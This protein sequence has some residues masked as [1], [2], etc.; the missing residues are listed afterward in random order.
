M[1]EARAVQAIK[2]LNVYQRINEVRKKVWY[3]RK[4]KDVS[5]GGSGNYKATTH[6]AVTALVRNHLIEHGVLIV[7]RLINSSMT[8][9]GKT[10]GGTPIF[11]YAGRFEVDFVNCDEPD[12]RIVYP[13]E[14]HANDSG[15]KAPGKAVSYATKYAILKLFNIETGENEEG[16]VEPYGGIEKVSEEQ[17]AELEALITEVGANRNAFLKVCKVEKLEDLPASK[18]EGAVQKLEAK[19]AG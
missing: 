17:V 15:D 18:Y 19:R 5:T 10:K 1:A 11:R 3:V 7:P 13:T 9:V 2:K 14:A 12:D 16:R 6:D 4:D 8:E